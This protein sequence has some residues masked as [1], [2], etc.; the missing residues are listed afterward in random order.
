MEDHCSFS[1]LGYIVK[2]KAL[3]R[4]PYIILEFF[5]PFALSPCLARTGSNWSFQEWFKDRA[6]KLFFKK[7]LASNEN[8]RCL[9]K[10]SSTVFLLFWYPWH[11]VGIYKLFMVKKYG[12]ILSKCWSMKIYIVI[13]KIF[14]PIV[15]TNARLESNTLQRMTK[16]NSKQKDRI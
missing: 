5:K 2:N 4:D 7:F 9:V 1:L 12:E 13:Q 3:K 16:S 8:G 14:P 6:S 10:D 11:F 15:S